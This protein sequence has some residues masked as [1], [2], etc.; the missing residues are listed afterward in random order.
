MNK[1]NVNINKNCSC[2]LK[3][4]TSSSSSSTLKQHS[5]SN[6]KIKHKNTPNPPTKKKQNKKAIT[7]TLQFISITILRNCIWYS[8][9]NTL[10]K[11]HVLENSSIFNHGRNWEGIVHFGRGLRRWPHIQITPFRLRNFNFNNLTIG[12]WLFSHLILKKVTKDYSYIALHY[13]ITTQAGSNVLYFMTSGSSLLK[14]DVVFF[15]KGTCF[16]WR[17]Q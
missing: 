5:N 17:I 2:N 1:L 11:I 16:S 3:K 6:N 12:A 10:K 7:W 4:N 13:F 8:K 15:K 14:C 9:V